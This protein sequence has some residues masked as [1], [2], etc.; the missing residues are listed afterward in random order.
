MCEMELEQ[1]Y[2]A[3]TQGRTI[4]E[5]CLH[6]NLAEHLNSEIGL[7]TIASI[8]SAKNWLRSS[9]LFRRIQKNPK[10]YEVALGQDVRK[11]VG[12]MNWEERIGNMVASSVEKLQGSELIAPGRGNVGNGDDMLVSTEFGD[13]MSK[14]NLIVSQS[15]SVCG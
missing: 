11:D 3:L 13:I 14:V 8:E 1:K 9:F 7:G 2:R 15:S 10:H 4:L 5:S 12:S 6:L